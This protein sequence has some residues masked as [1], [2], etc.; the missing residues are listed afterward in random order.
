[1]VRSTTCIAFC[2]LVLLFTNCG[3]ILSGKKQ[4]VVFTTPCTSPIHITIWEPKPDQIFNE[5]S[6]QFGNGEYLKISE[7]VLDSGSQY[8]SVHRPKPQQII[9][10]SAINPAST[11]HKPSPTKQDLEKTMASNTRIEINHFYYFS[12]TFNE[13]ALLNFVIPW[14]WMIDAYTGAV[15]RWKITNPI[16]PPLKPASKPKL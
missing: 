3:T 2:S 1:M 14:N 10:F 7:F 16:A 12:P 13:S 11:G 6:V 15:L 5:D 8:V 9:T 4:K